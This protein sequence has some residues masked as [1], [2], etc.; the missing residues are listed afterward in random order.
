MDS[1]GKM[2]LNSIFQFYE[3]NKD[4]IAL[5]IQVG[6]ITNNNKPEQWENAYNSFFSLFD[7]DKRPVFCL[8]NKDYGEDGNSLTRTS[9]IPDKLVPPRDIWMGSD[10]DNYVCF[11]KFHS[12]IWAVLV[13]EFAPR[14][15]AIKWANT[16][17]SD[18]SAVPFIILTHGFLNNEGQVFDFTNLECNQQFSQKSYYLGGEYLNDSMEIFDKLIYYNENVKMLI[19]GH[20]ISKRYIEFNTM[21]N[22]NGE[23]VYFL[24]VNYQ[25]YEEGGAGI[26]GLLSCHGDVFSLRS[27]STQSNKYGDIL[28]EFTV[29]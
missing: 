16:V 21:L 23:K 25:H 6:D 13:L 11:F 14:E 7:K 19:C 8:G 28:Y 22:S 18:Y 24:M 20:A 10:Y 26:I 5:C 3:C 15:E 9:K 17:L 2:Y 4:S 27:Y 29:Q 12:R 1:R